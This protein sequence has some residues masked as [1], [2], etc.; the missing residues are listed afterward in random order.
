MNFL[1][2]KLKQKNIIAFSTTRNFKSV[3]TWGKVNFKNINKALREQKIKGRII[4]PE[5][6]HG[7]AIKVV[8]NKS[9]MIIKGVDGLVTK[10][11]NLSLGVLTADCIP[12]IF[13]DPKKEI[14]GIAHAGYK[15]ILLGIIEEL[16]A[17]FKKMGTEAKDIKVSIGP[18]IG[19]CCYE[20]SE[21]IK[22]KALARYSFAKINK[23][24]DSYYWDLRATVTEILK[25][26][27]ITQSNVEISPLCTFETPFLYSARKSGNKGFG[28]FL[29]AVG[30]YEN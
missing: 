7:K 30:V 16:I 18:S 14:I 24:E 17:T 27:K 1:N 12:I 26:N 21:N 2:Y 5:Q 6:I 4:I 10:E 3:K 13:Y 22:N 25:Q 20:I 9:E 8:N 19:A 15:G 11:K 23:R 29:T 28:E